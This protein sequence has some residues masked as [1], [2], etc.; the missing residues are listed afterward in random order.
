LPKGRQ[1]NGQKKKENEIKK[2]KK[3]NNGKQNITH[4]TKD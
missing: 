2:R 3:G 1:D 4:K